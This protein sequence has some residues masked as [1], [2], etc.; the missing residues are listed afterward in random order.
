[1]GRKCLGKLGFGVYGFGAFDH[2]V[3]DEHGDHG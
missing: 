1:V 3:G 2:A